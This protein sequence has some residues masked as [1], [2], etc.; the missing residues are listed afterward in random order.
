MVV[1]GVALNSD[2]AIAADFTWMAL[3]GKEFIRA[4]PHELFNIADLDDADAITLNDV[5]TELRYNNFTILIGHI[6][7]ID[8]AGHYFNNVS[9]PE[10][11]RKI[12]D[13][14]AILE[15]II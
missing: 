13:A 1:N 10:M 7:G 8:H 2:V 9:H 3:Y 5:N 15:S 12:L 11:Q 14:E 4:Y 6:I